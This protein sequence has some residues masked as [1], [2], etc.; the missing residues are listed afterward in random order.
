MPDGNHSLHAGRQLQGQPAA[1]CVVSD[2]HDDGVVRNRAQR[3]QSAKDRQAENLPRAYVIHETDRLGI[4]SLFAGTCQRL[5]D[6]HSLPPGPDDDDSHGPDS[7]SIERFGA[8]VEVREHEPAQLGIA[9]A[10]RIK[11]FDANETLH[12]LDAIDTST[13]NTFASCLDGLRCT[14]PDRRKN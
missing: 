4:R 5:G 13:P 7:T 3:V 12:I 1:C 14:S 11:H 9:D 6:D 10:G 2:G 8:G